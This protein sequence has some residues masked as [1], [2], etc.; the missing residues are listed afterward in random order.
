M[1]GCDCIFDICVVDVDWLKVWGELG[2]R[3]K[4]GEYRDVQLM[5][6]GRDGE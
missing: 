4:D 5:I 1:L 2:V 3:G 6:R